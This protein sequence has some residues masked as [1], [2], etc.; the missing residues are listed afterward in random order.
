MYFTILF[1]FNLLYFFGAIVMGVGSF[2]S[3]GKW[4]RRLCLGERL[5]VSMALCPPG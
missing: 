5:G 4:E 1:C 3:S 2:L